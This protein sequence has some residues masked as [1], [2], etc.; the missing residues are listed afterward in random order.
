[1]SGS[2]FDGVAGAYAI[3]RP[4]YPDAL[5]DA[6]GSALGRPF[7][8]IDAVDVGAGTGIGTAAFV[9]RGA[10]V[11]A[12]DPARRMLSELI[13][14][15]PAA[16][17]IC[18]DGNHL[19]LG[20]AVAD[21]VT[22]AQALHWT[23]PERSVPEALRLLRPGGVLAAW[24]NVPDFE[25]PWVADQRDR[26]CAAS[27]SYHGFAGSDLGERLGGPPFRLRAEHHRFWWSRQLSPEQ[28]VTMLGTQSYIAALADP[29]RTAFL[30]AE[31]VLLRKL[32][33]NGMLIEPYVT[34]LT[35]AYR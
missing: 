20:T 27:P 26:L 8:V 18:A 19:P 11:V 25:V 7:S 15:V 5:Y 33:P 23:D 22:Y 29:E 28:H 14:A 24:W 35:I 32:F 3:S 13:A 10:T 6:I 34:R 2:L 1:M 4:T 30:E 12:V 16:R 9:A 21:L 31:L 17:A